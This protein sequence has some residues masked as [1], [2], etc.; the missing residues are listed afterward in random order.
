MLAGI[1][2]INPAQKCLGINNGKIGPVDSSGGAIGAMGNLI[3]MSF[4]V[5]ASTRD[6]VNYLASNFGIAEPAFAQATGFDR[7]SPFIKLWAGFR[8]IV[9]LIL[10]LVFVVI[11]FAIML[12][13]RIDPRTVMSIENQIPKIIV[14]L[15]MV[16]FSFAIAGLMIDLMWVSIYLVISVFGNIH[17]AILAKDA[18]FYGQN[19]IQAFGEFVGFGDV[20]L[21][22]SGSVGNIFLNLLTINQDNGN[23]PILSGIFNAVDFVKNLAGG[24]VAGLAS[25]FALLVVIFAVAYSLFRLWFTLIKAYVFILLDI[26]FAPFWILA[27]MMP[28]SKLSFDA[29]LRDL[30]SNLLAFPA[31][32]V[33]F[34]LARVFMDIFAQPGTNTSFIPLIGN[35][36]APGVM[37]SIIGLGFILF[38]PGIVE[39]MRK[40]LNAPQID[41]ASIWKGVGV[42]VG[43]TMGIVKTGQGILKAAGETEMTDIDPTTGRVNYGRIGMGRAIRKVLPF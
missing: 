3:A 24:L 39:T 38:T 40:V 41:L 4:P 9:Y 23:I 32:I 16:T 37:G 11:G 35:P 28:G 6:Y 14:A 26:V 42:G 29:W 31:T 7:L 10:V 27:G 34:L 36:G 33:L 25:V 30:G 13:V 21:G 5:S 43:R 19:A 22:S 17:P 12:R 8:D 18:N 2:P 1:D 15:V 20:V